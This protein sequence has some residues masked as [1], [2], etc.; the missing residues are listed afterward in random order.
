M[1]YLNF[2]LNLL[3]VLS[4]LFEE[5]SVTRAGERLGRTQSA[6][7]NSLRKLREAMND[8]LFIRGPDGLILTPKARLLEEQVR[9]ILSVAERCL[10][11]DEAFDPRIATGRC[12]L[13]A[14]DRLSLPVIFPLLKSLG[15]RAPNLAVDVVTTDRD[16]ALTL[17][18]TDQLDAA[19]GWFDSPPIRF[20]A[21]LLSKEGF[22]CL[23]RQGHPITEAKR[24]VELTTILSFPHLVV[25][26]TRDQKAVFDLMLARTGRQ[27]N[28]MVSV[29]NFSMV[30]KVLGESDMI[31]VFT[32]RVAEAL[33]HDFNLATLPVPLEIAPLEHLLV[34]H[35][36]NDADQ[37]QSWIRQQI[38]LV[39]GGD[40][41]GDFGG[42]A[43]RTDAP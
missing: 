29:S 35:N 26:A 20:R 24:P 2:D 10:A 25:S 9:E 34:W 16:Q 43:N 12:R 19:I 27:R 38:R 28:A 39:S 4:V 15:E 21:E 30:P 42:A 3:K 33:A 36:R 11:G 17:L 41:D 31:G 22:I 7:S 37:Q 5:R 14:P 23:C 18:D 40:I 6:I 8:P 13:G 32:E 1:K